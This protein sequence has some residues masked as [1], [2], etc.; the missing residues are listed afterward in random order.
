MHLPCRSHRP[1]R[2]GRSRLR[3]CTSRH[4]LP[5][6][7]GCSILPPRTSHR[8]NIAD[9]CHRTGC[10]CPELPRCRCRSSR[11]RGPGSS[12]HPIR[13]IPGRRRRRTPDCWRCRPH[14]TY[15]RPV[16]WRHTRRTPP[17][18]PPRPR[19]SSCPRRPLRSSILPGAR[20][21][22]CCCRRRRCRIRTR[23]CR[24]CPPRRCP[25]WWSCCP[26]RRRNL[27]RRPGESLHSGTTHS[28]ECA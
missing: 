27:Q 17:G 21:R 8:R 22:R 3:R 20:R 18:P 12:P 28:I 1:R 14:P 5:S 6:R 9:C 13:H 23:S 25:R 24:L 10:T 15:S 4:H 26:R 16:R 11:R 2:R 7:S 19:S